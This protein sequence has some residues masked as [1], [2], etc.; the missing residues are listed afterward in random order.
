MAIR[1]IERELKKNEA[2]EKKTLKLIKDMATKNQHG[3][4]HQQ[5]AKY[6]LGTGVVLCMLGLYQ[7]YITCML[8]VIYPEVMSFLT[9]SVKGSWDK[10]QWLSYW[11]VF[12]LFTLIDQFASTLLHY[13]PFYHFLKLCFL[14]FLYLPQVKGATLVNN[15]LIL[16]NPAKVQ[17]KTLVHLRNQNK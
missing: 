14:V 1:Q 5:I 16:P 10:K 9:L 2:D 12:G 13:I 17:A 4:T 6:A 8:G 11:V 15:A 7:I 3:L